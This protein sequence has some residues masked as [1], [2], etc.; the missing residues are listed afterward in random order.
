MLIKTIP[1]VVAA[2]T[3]TACTGTSNSASDEPVKMSS[4]SKD[5]VPELK[6]WSEAP[7]KSD[8][9]EFKVCTKESLAFLTTFQQ[10]CST[11]SVSPGGRIM[12]KTIYPYTESIS[13]SSTTD[14]KQVSIDSE[15]GE[16]EGGVQIKHQFQQSLNYISVRVT[17]V[18]F[19]TAKLP[20]TDQSID[21]PMTKTC[22]SE[23]SVDSVDDA[24]HGVVEANNCYIAYRNLPQIKE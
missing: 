17:T 21:L 20:D 15:I 22:L 6:T 8:N 12:D 19:R 14:G 16:V 2:L 3:L 23:F 24:P 9:V 7:V 1:L 5:W 13:K 11:Y 4:H 10:S 18:S